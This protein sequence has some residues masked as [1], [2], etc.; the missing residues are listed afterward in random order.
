MALP[1]YPADLAYKP[2]ADT[3]RV[4]EATK[5]PVVTEM[6]DGPPLARR[7]GL[8]RRAKL[9]YEIGFREMADYGRFRAFH[10]TTLIDGTQRFGMPVWIPAT[11]S[12][13]NRTVMIENGTYQ[14][15]S[16]ALGVLVS[17]TLIV[18]D[19]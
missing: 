14:A 12:Y 5:P 1:T 18:W 19:W 10:E 17:F 16:W 9:A 15:Q 2:F 7:S 6:E 3:F 11:Q 13:A 8:G 4:L